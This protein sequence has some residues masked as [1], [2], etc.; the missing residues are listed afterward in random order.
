VSLVL[1]KVTAVSEKTRLNVICYSCSLCNQLG[2]IINNLF[3]GIAN[4]MPKQSQCFSDHKLSRL[5][6]HL[7]Q[8]NVAGIYLSHELG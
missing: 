4:E 3:S 2:L 1:T 5:S 6:Q 7:S 8:V